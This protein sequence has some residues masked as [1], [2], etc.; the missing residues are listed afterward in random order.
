MDTH[1]S[2]Q[3]HYCKCFRYFGAA[4]NLPGVK[5][6]LG[7]KDSKPK[8]AKK[9]DVR[10][11]SDYFGFKD[12]DDEAL[13]HIEQDAEKKAVEDAIRN[14]NKHQ[15]EG[16]RPATDEPLEPAFP[17]PSREE[18]HQMMVEKRKQELMKRYVSPVLT[19]EL[20]KQKEEIEVV[21]GKRKP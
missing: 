12:E 20:A 19:E 11:D 14:W 1:T 5:E 8:K 7:Q 3:N 18:L 4:R 2:K 9:S 16:L 10:V 21:L 15:A 6:A 13:K 17:I